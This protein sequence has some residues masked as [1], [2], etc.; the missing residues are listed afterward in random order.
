MDGG[1]VTDSYTGI[2]KSIF[3]DRAAD[4]KGAQ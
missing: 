1:N 2:P 3:T 4:V